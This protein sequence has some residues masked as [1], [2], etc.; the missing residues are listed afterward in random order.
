MSAL[1]AN[2]A[3]MLAGPALVQDQNIAKQLYESN[4]AVCHSDSARGDGDM[5]G[6]MTIAATDLRLLTHTHNGTFPIPKV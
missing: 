5:S 1:A 2:A 3:I 6:I 4:C